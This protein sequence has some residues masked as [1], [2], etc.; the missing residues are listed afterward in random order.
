[1]QEGGYASC[2]L[3]SIFRTPVPTHPT[4][5]TCPNLHC[6]RGL[7]LLCVRV[8]ARVWVYVCVHSLSLCIGL[9]PNEGPGG[10]SAESA[11][12]GE[13]ALRGDWPSSIA[14]GGRTQLCSS[15]I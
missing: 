8:C 12:R 7:R 13:Q 10:G 9:Q 6:A 3:T 2:P 5:L 4:F 11:E 15:T 14:I 1:M